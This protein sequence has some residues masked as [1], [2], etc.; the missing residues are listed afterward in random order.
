[1]SSRREHEDLNR[2]VYL[3]LVGTSRNAK[4]YLSENNQR[5]ATKKTFNKGDTILRMI[6]EFFMELQARCHLTTKAL[7]RR[8]TFMNNIPNP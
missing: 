2:V 3:D 1:M 6:A 5:N 4:V 7:S 8:I